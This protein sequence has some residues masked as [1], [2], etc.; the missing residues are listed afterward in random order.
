MQSGVG[1]FSGWHCDADKIEIIVDDRPAKVA[2]YGTPRKDTQTKCGDTDNG[3]GLLFM[4]NLYGIG[5]HKVRALADGIEFDSAE[6]TV[7]YLDSAYIRDLASYVPIT[8]PAMGKEAVL[9]WQESMQG[10]VIS[11]VQDLDF[12]MEDAVKA[13][14]GDWAGTWQ[15]AWAPDSTLA[16]SIEVVEIPGGMAF[17]PTSITIN[18]TGCAAQAKQAT[19]IT[20]F[21]AMVTEVVMND[22]SEVEIQILPVESMTAAA[23][24]FVFDSGPCAGLDGAFSIFKPDQ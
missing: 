18:G 5:P 22:N 20:S 11:D 1:L 24:I 14:T 23:G 7:D 2:A 3:F 8:V 15:S 16:M 19:P 12:S 13:A 21:D 10:Y 9:V 17:Q 6:F 4:F